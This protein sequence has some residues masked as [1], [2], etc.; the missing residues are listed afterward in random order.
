MIERTRDVKEVIRREAFL[1]LA[2]K[3]SIRHLTI[4]ERIQV[5]AIISLQCDR[6]I[7]ESMFLYVYYEILSLSVV[8]CIGRFY[9]VYCSC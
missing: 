6:H 1:W 4:E 7:K 8:L 3:C 9:F 5:R 2:N